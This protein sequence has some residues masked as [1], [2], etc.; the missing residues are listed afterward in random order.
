M[1][2]DPFADLAD[3]VPKPRR[4]NYDEIV[5]RNA[6]RTGLDADLI[7]AV[8][9]QESGGNPRAVSPKGARGP[10]QLMP[11]TAKRFNV[12]DPHD[13]EQA[14]RGGTDYLKFLNDRFKGNR[15]LVLAGYNAGEGA[16]DKFKGI[17]PYRETQNYVKS[18]NARL[19]QQRQRD[20]FADLADKFGDLADPVTEQSLPDSKQNSVPPVQTATSPAGFPRKQ[21][22]PSRSYW[23]RVRERME[24][25]Q[26]SSIPAATGKRGE[27]LRRL[28]QQRTVEQSQREQEEATRKQVE[29][30]YR[31]RR[32][33]YGAPTPTGMLHVIA[34]PIDSLAGLLRPDEENIARET[35]ERLKQQQVAAEPEVQEIR[36]EYGE[37]STPRRVATSAL[38]KGGAGLLDFAGGL[39]ELGGLLPKGVIPPVDQ[40]SSWAKKRAEIIEAGASGA[41]LREK[42]NLSSLIIG[43]TELEEVERGVP[44]KIAQGVADLGVGL[45]EI[46]LLKRATKLPFNKLLALEAAMRNSEK[47][48]DQQLSKTAEAYALGTAL[49]RHLS[50]PVSAA[51]S[52]IPTAA[53]T[54]YEVSQGRMSPLDAAIATGIQTAQGAIL[55]TP[56]SRGRARPVESVIK[57]VTAPREQPVETVVAP[58][59]NPRLRDVDMELAQ[60]RQQLR[61]VPRDVPATELDRRLLELTGERERLSKQVETQPDVSAQREAVESA[62]QRIEPRPVS[63]TASLRDEGLDV[64]GTSVDEVGERSGQGL[65]RS[66]VAST[67]EGLPEGTDLSGVNASGFLRPDH[68]VKLKGAPREHWSGNTYE[69]D[70]GAKPTKSVVVETE[71]SEFDIQKT[72]PHIYNRDTNVMDA[73]GQPTK[74][75]TRVFESKELSPDA[76]RDDTV[77]YRGMSG[78]EVQSVLKSGEIKSNSS[79]N[80]GDQVGRSTSF[81]ADPSSARAYAAGFAPWYMEP[82]FESPSYVVK[83]KRPS[84]AKLESS[85]SDNYLEV[86]HPIPLSDVLDV[87]EIRLARQKAGSQEVVVDPDTK[88]AKVGSSAGPL[89]E[90]VVRKVDPRTLS[91]VPPAD[92]GI[93]SLQRFY[94]RDYGEVVKSPDQQGA[95]RGRTKVYEADNPNAIHYVKSGQLT[96]AGNQRMVPVREPATEKPLDDYLEPSAKPVT[97]PAAVELRKPSTT[98]IKNAAMEA[99]RVALDLPE[100]AQAQPRKATEVHARAIEANRTNPRATDTLTEQALR[101]GRTFTDVETAQVRLR[102][103]EIKNRV[104]ELNQELAE[105]DPATVAGKAAEIDSLVNE[106]DRLSQATRAAGTEWG[107]AGVA[108]QQ[109]IDQDF[110]LVS[111]IANFRRAKRGVETPE[112]R[113]RIEDLQQRLVKAE[114]ERDAANERATQAAI[115]KRIDRVGRQRQRK[116]SLTDLSAEFDSLKGQLAQIKASEGGFFKSERGAVDPE[117]VKILVAMAQN[118]MRAGVTKAAQLIDEIH[119]ATGDRWTRSEIADVLAD[120]VTTPQDKR[121]QTQLGKQRAKM[122]SEMASGEFTTSQRQRPAYNRET[123]RLTKEV[124][125][126]K[127]TYNRMRYKA[128][129]S[130]TEIALDEAAKLT[131]IPKTL[132][133]IG[134]ISAVFRQGGYYA[135][136]HPVEGLARP[137]RDMLN[138]ISELGWRNVEVKIKDD[139]D[140]KA[141]RDAGVEFTGVD[142][143][144]PNLTKREEGFLGGEYLDL[145]AKGKYNYPGKF[146]KGVKDVS[147]RTFVSF[148]DAQRLY[149]GKQI[150]K[151]M[152]ETQRNN[153]KELKAIA[154]LINIGTGR[155]NLGRR[156]NQYAPALNIAMFSPRLVASRIQLLNNMVNPVTM[157]RMY[158]Q[159]PAAAKQMIKDNAKFIAA[160]T[161]ILLLAKAA[162]ADVSLDPDD[163]EFLKIRIGNTVY[164]Q[165]TGLQQPLRTI[166]N[167]AR[168]AGPVDSQTLQTGD[169]YA[170]KSMKE[171]LDPFEEGSFTRSKLNPAISPLIDFSTGTD[172][173][174]REFSTKREA[175][176][177]LTPL[178]AKDIVEGFQS[179]GALG[180]VK[181]T[182]S[183]VGIGVGS[184]PPSP[185]KPKTH[186][187]KM[188]RR[189]ARPPDSGPRTDT[190]IETDRQRAQLRAR[191]R[192]GEDVSADIA[193]LGSKITE[194]QAKAILSARN[195]T[196]L[197]EDVNRLGIKDALMVYKVANADQRA[198]IK[199][200]LTRKASLADT[201][202]PEEQATVKAMMTEIGLS[203]GRTTRPTRQSRESRATRQ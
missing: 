172:F 149:V 126:I 17:P 23:G 183:A 75:W 111:M 109:A 177:M 153:P 7:K 94:H 202:K 6:A 157:A 77:M 100:L 168:A 125:Q 34:N 120:H 188:A 203:S 28:G 29:Q 45:G 47:P 192:R 134:D 133:S 81:A 101:G 195:K 130:R 91:A 147:E 121:R 63:E 194:R 60:I 79:M 43:Q 132:K 22:T 115:Q 123:L 12:T 33:A 26:P 144:D 150:L 112:E 73:Q 65:D 98:A 116:E 106:F 107:R 110:N 14:I 93:E 178:F 53:Q 9:H 201:L 76:P 189:L 42:R 179:E 187:E 36:K 1:P 122:E 141:L 86:D 5:N 182:P 70:V 69:Y 114:T 118:R 174:G 95:R 200:L 159:S 136:T 193:A 145:I 199:P 171:I 83:V 185:E 51:I 4:G 27:L 13:P 49:D 50:R 88:R 190:E 198:N 15:D 67:F 129:K 11:G 31:G 127:A 138:S 64:H 85:H 113:A 117:A 169:Y 82:T 24:E 173:M 163:A 143:A 155:G 156:G 18:I 40:L 39:A 48:I 103:Q 61:D 19:G 62:V 56:P 25:V 37:M 66:Q 57:P 54:S 137:T 71:Y 140:F 160:T 146:V 58:V 152:T 55:T 35:Q 131:N 97:E 96:G 20:N 59:A 180:A 105:A 181:A 158:R 139:T 186:A 128:T 87:W 176:E 68:A 2:D 166:V 72:R 16:V 197:Y 3:P 104:N 191:S 99:D 165:L 41:P 175:A 52:G 32:G 30:E 184:Y 78:A 90:Y 151:G 162:G 167:L 8:I 38:A 148:L 124:E 74:G 89:S 135:L 44:E 21:A 92:E 164:D 196:R 119:A 142:K 46:I 154:N 10:M 161:A 102:A 108:R 170:G 80:L 84:D